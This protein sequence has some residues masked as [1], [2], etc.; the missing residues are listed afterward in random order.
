MSK[1]TRWWL[2]SIGVLAALGGA[3]V[4]EYF[5]QRQISTT[6]GGDASGRMATRPRAGPPERSIG[7]NNLNLQW[8]PN[9]P[10]DTAALDTRA[11]P[12]APQSKRM[13]DVNKSTS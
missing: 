10:F 12:N 4:W 5:H 9:S 3:L 11:S 8:P 1:Q 13:A 7:E 2:V 6:G